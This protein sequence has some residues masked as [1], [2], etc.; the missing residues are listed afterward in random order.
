MGK[1]TSDVEIIRRMMRYVWPKGDYAIKGRV[2]L[3]LALLGAGKLCN[4]QVPFFFKQVIDSLNMP[5]PEGGTVMTVAGAVLIGYGLSRIGSFAF[6]EL[7]NAVFARVAQGA[8]RRVADSIFS[9][10]LSL[11]LSFHLSRQTGG[12][13]RAIDRGTKGISF[14][15]TST[16]LHLAPTILEI[17]MVCGILSYK[18]GTP[19][20][21]VTLG[22]MAAYTLFTVSV[23]SW[24][25][26]FRRQAN[27]ADNEAA[28]RVIDSLINYEAVKASSIG[29]GYFGNE[30]Y[31]LARY[32]A[33]MLKYETASLK[34]AGSLAFLNAGQNTIFSL[35]LASMMAMAA[36]GVIQGH[37]TVGDLVLINQLVFQLSM[38]LN[39]LGSV[40]R[41]LR[42]ALTDMDTLFNLQAI[43][44]RI[45]D[46]PNARPVV[47]DGGEIRF[48]NVTFGYHPTRPI[49][50]N[51]TFTIPRGKKVAIVGPSG[52][53]KSTVLRLMFRFYEPQSGRILVDG[54]DI[55]DVQ[56]ASLRRLIGVVPQDTALFNDTIYHNIAYGNTQATMDQVMHAAQ[57]AQIHHVIERLPDGYQTR[58]GERGLMISGGEKQ[59]VA[60][61]RT[62]LKDPPILFFDEATSALDTHTEQSILA[63]IRSLLDEKHC[64]SVFIA[65]R[66]RTISDADLI[67]VLK[68]GEVVEQGRHESLLSGVEGQGVYRDMWWSQELTEAEKQ[69]TEEDEANNNNGNGNGNAK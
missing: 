56:L 61:A 55:R 47:F 54:Q 43:D 49:L 67:V 1:S 62:I 42:Q 12:L 66:L 46:A 17:S 45:T 2:V 58:V 18:F 32:N 68:D 11:D 3:A 51:A 13:S 52:C 39:F 26:K 30:K 28:T 53:G 29:R 6:Q 31:E 64:T 21:L 27:A 15:L 24:R 44:Q 22:T 7:R 14:V 20:A 19:Y 8:I 9:H 36:Q 33:A 41:D 48:E 5:V 60:L 37:L 69:A 40:Y 34:I 35:S 16:V 4:V 50:R 65:H 25:T 38:P 63:N 23:T 59:R 10:L 57:R